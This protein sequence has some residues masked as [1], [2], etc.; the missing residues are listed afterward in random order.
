MIGQDSFVEINQ[1]GRLAS[2]YITALSPI[3]WQINSMTMD[4]YLTGRF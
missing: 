1:E 4:Y 2:I 3:D